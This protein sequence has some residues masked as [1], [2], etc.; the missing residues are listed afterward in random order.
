MPSPFENYQGIAAPLGQVNINTDA[1]IPATYM[2][3]A[4]ANLGAGLFA[5]WRYEENGE[6]K[7]D[8]ILN[9]TPYDRASILIAGANF[10]C[11]SSREA[12]VWALLRFGIRCVIAP[13]YADI[14][15]ENCF[16]NGLLPALVSPADLEIALAQSKVPHGGTFSLTSRAPVFSCPKAR[17]LNFLFPP[18]AAMPCCV[19][20]MTSPRHCAM[21]KPWPISTSKT[22]KPDP[23][24]TPWKTQHEQPVYPAA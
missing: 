18:C 5:R 7:T 17:R 13:S 1:I 22:A 9:Q 24:F 20:M 21:K 19:A 15:Y 23:G 11:G 6:P 3:S 8:F 14:F 4:S 2:R 12:A 10:G 16:R